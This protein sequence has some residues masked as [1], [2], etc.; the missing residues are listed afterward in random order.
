MMSHLKNALPVVHIREAKP[1]DIEA[2]TDLLEELFFIEADFNI[3]S[4]KQFDGL[5]QLMD[6]QTS[7]L[8]V[9]EL[10]GEI[11]GMCTLQVLIST[12]EG[13]PV[14]M[15]EDVIVHKKYRRH[16]IGHQLLFAVEQYAVQAG[17]LRLQ[18]LA[19]KKND[20]ALQ[21]YEKEKWKKTQ[22]IAFRKS[23]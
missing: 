21:F 4:Q 12:A 16:N 5:T 23:K 22:L 2:M 9:A 6:S 17:L 20:C 8:W 14:G 3:D 1:P 19:D 7:K 15:I 11:V 13:G 10:E 18:L